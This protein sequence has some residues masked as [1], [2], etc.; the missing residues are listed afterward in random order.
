M[1]LLFTLFFTNFLCE[2]CFSVQ[3]GVIGF[4]KT[5]AKELGKF[6]IRQGEHTLQNFISVNL[7]FV[8]LFYQFL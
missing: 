5:A 1:L 2:Y 8:P 7:F 4:T 6:G 3:A